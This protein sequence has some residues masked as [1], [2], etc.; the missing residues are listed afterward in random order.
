MRLGHR[1]S[2]DIDLF[3]PIE[4]DSEQL[5]LAIQKHETLYQLRIMPNTVNAVAEGVKID[6]IAHRYNQLETIETIDNIRFYSLRGIA[7]IKLSAIGGRGARK[8]F[9]DVT[10]LL[11]VISFSEM[12]NCFERKYP[13]ADTFHTIRSLSYFE[14][15]DKE[16][17]IILSPTTP[18]KL[19]SWKSV[20]STIVEQIKRL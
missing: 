16:D 19:R 3:T 8:D 4:F 11:E 14:D 15:A 7:A 9:Y 18:Q 20:Q 6:C 1:I 10:A 12:L 5:S 2:V 13:N 17:D